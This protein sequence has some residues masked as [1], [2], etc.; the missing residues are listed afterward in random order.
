MAS[1]RAAAARERQLTPGEL[2]PEL[3]RLE[4]E[5]STLAPTYEERGLDEDDEE[6]DDQRSR[7]PPPT[8]RRTSTAGR[9]ALDAFTEGSSTLDVSSTAWQ[10]GESGRRN[11]A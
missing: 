2:N 1:L 9:L 7:N 3:K 5:H 10:H 4:V 11:T 6:V 8:S